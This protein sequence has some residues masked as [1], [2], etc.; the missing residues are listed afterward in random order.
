MAPF[1][2]SEVVRRHTEQL[3]ALPT[4][5]GVAEGLSVGRPCVVVLVESRSAAATAGIPHLLDGF[6]TQVVETG[7]PKALQRGEPGTLP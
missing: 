7:A 5:V 6:R 4:V 3:M 1:D 2:L